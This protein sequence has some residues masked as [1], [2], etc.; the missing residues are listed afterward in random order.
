M[1][2]GFTEPLTQ[3]AGLVYV[4]Y[5]VDA[6]RRLFLHYSIVINRKMQTAFPQCACVSQGISCIHSVFRGAPPP[7]VF[8][9]VSSFLP[10]KAPPPLF[11]TNY[12]S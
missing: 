12:W 6:C 3:Q 7:I 9:S 10:S 1:G 4:E 2:L 5:I 11:Q 8:S